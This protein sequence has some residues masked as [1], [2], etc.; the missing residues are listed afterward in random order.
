MSCNVQHRH[1]HIVG[2]TTITTT[3]MMLS[4][5]GT[6]NVLKG[7]RCSDEETVF[8]S[9]AS[10]S[11]A[12]RH[13]KVN[14]EQRACEILFASNLQSLQ[15]QQQ[16]LLHLNLDVFLFITRHHKPFI[17]IATGNCDGRHHHH[18]SLS[19]FLMVIFRVCAFVRRSNSL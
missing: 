12:H 2:L 11:V 5:I 4:A 17:M 9:A 14:I 8:L 15:Q 10:L 6:R 3:T 7:E 19:S 18:R 16:H 1:T 13:S